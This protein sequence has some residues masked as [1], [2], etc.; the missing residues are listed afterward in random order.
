MSNNYEAAIRLAE[1][2][3]SERA[4]A[5]ARIAERNRQI[6]GNV[7]EEP[8][9]LYLSIFAPGRERARAISQLVLKE[10]L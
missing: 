1:D 8:T 6:L 2:E 4:L 10:S 9:P 5:E 7:S 3:W